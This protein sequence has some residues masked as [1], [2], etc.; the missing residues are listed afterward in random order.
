MRRW[1]VLFVAAAI[2]S[3]P[4]PGRAH[5]DPP[6][7]FSTGVSISIGMFRSDG[8]TGVVGTIQDCEQVFYRATLAKPPH[9]LS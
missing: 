7:C 9:T 6:G 2:V 1:L 8:V 5:Q 3:T 4:R